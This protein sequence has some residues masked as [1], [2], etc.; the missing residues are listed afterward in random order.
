MKAKYNRGFTLIEIMIV[1]VVIGIL[2][3]IA[4]PAYQDY[5]LRAKRAEAK[6]ALALAA[7]RL[8]RCFTQNNT[9]AGC[10][11]NAVSDSGNWNISA[12]AQDENGYTLRAAVVPG[13]HTDGTCSPM[14][15]SNTGATTPANAD[16]WP[17]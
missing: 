15:L 10:A 7:Q 16:C 4:L 6:S 14:T 3:T 2:A 12:T 9:Y 17:Q 11:I 8:E 5:V 13:Q 1:V